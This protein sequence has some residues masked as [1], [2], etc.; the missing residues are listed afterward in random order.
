MVWQNTR[1]PFTVTLS[2]F[3]SLSSCL[4]FFSPL[5]LSSL[6][7]C[8]LNPVDS[9]YSWYPNTI[10]NFYYYLILF[11]FFLCPTEERNYA[12]GGNIV[13]VWHVLSIRSVV[14]E[15]DFLSNFNVLYVNRTTRLERQRYVWKENDRENP[16]KK[17]ESWSSTT[18]GHGA[19]H[20]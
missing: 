20:H 17:T 1:N 7:L 14:T 6:P 15:Q 18:L 4:L 13:Y 9:W 16:R 12:K 3:L 10:W 2:L 19:R 8:K 5:L 11:D